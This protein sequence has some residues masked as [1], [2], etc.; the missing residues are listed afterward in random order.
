MKPNL[1]R[2]GEFI[3]LMALLGSMTALSI[4]AMFPAMSN[5]QSDLHLTQGNQIQLIVPSLFLGLGL[6]QLLFGPSSDAFGRKPPMLWGL[7][8]F[9]GGSLLSMLAP[10]FTI[11]LIGRFLQGLGAAATRVVSMA[12]IR[13]CYTGRAMARVMSFIMSVFILVPM[14]APSLGQLILKLGNW[15]MIFAMFVLLALIAAFWLQLRMPETLAPQQ[16]RPFTL[17]SLMQ[18]LKI[19][20]RTRTTLFYTVAIGLVFGAFIGYLG[21]S[22]A[23]LKQQYQ[24]GDLFPLY[25][26]L[27]ALGIGTASL[28][29][30]RLVQHFGMYK[31]CVYAILTTTLLAVIYLMVW[32]GR[33]AGQPPLNSFMLYLFLSFL[34]IGLLFGNL[35][36]LAMEPVGHIAGLGASLIG[37]ISTLL[38]VGI[39]TLI[40]QAYNGTVLPLVLGFALTGFSV[41]LLLL[42]TPSPKK[43]P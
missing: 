11:M 9:I 34:H 27:L 39:G 30:T 32:V 16:R 2:F 21:S 5:M 29:N 41:S 18:G 6:G 31:I 7:S 3:V 38:S 14:L 12:L 37:A 15:R 35:N 33:Y 10:N 20:V 36:A 25:F 13:D 42:L 24:L 19:I 43:T 8:I 23:I 4:D 26:G 40:G 22:E 28:L 1:P 17:N